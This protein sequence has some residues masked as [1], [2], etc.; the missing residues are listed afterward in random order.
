MLVTRQFKTEHCHWPINKLG[1]IFDNKPSSSLRMSRF[2]TAIS[3]QPDWQGQYSFLPQGENPF[4]Q[5]YHQN[6]TPNN[7]S[8]SS[9]A[10]AL[11]G[12]TTA[13]V[14]QAELAPQQNNANSPIGDRDTLDLRK[15]PSGA[16]EHTQQAQE[17]YVITSER[18]EKQESLSGSDAPTVPLMTG[19]SADTQ[20]RYTQVVEGPEEH[21]PRDEE[22]PDDDDM[23]HGDEYGEGVAQPRTAA[24]RTAQRRKMKRFRLTH[25]QTRFL[26]SEFA[27]QPHPDA[28]HRERLSREIPGLSPRQ[29]QVWFQN[30]YVWSALYAG[31]VIL[32]KTLFKSSQDQ[33]A[34]SGRPRSHD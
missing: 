18:V 8:R 16:A 3:T 29:V 25:Q 13:D 2:D 5:S 12:T 34:H 21:I 23:V 33:A 6:E 20:F 22:I 11:P 17:P 1:V 26:M 30:R 14:N 31:K 15:R 24:E 32:I 7:A 27:K 9:G 28:A 10:S 19:P 4:S